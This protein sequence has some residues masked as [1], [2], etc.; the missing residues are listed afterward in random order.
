MNDFFNK[1]NTHVN[2]L[3][4]DENRKALSSWKVDVLRHMTKMLQ[5]YEELIENGALS[6]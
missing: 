3:W 5:T 1:N 6:K 2:K 4:K